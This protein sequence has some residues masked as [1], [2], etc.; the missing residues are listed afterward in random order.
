MSETGP[1]SRREVTLY[2]GKLQTAK[3]PVAKTLAGE[4]TAPFPSFHG[5]YSGLMEVAGN[6]VVVCSTLGFL[7]A[8]RPP[9]Y[10]SQ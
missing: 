5:Q 9:R 8:S 3:P 6:G 4:L 10:T 7:Y 1:S 2:T